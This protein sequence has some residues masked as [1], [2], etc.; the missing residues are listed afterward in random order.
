MQAEDTDAGGALE[1][2]LT[3]DDQGVLTI[4]HE[5]TNTGEGVLDIDDLLAFVPLPATAEEVLDLTG[6]WC[7]ERHPQRAAL[8]HGGR[9]RES[10]RG[11]TG[12]DATL[13]LTVGEPG[14]SFTQGE[15]AA[16]HVAWSGDHVHLVDRLPEGAGRHTGLLGGGA[17]LRAGEM[18]LARATLEAIC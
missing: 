9:V 11:R 1:C 16:A 7:R 3:I 8:Q 10:R 14:F 4:R 6:R 15:V 18:R 2:T 12:H 13:L 17:L 5:I